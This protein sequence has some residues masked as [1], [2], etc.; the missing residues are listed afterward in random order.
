M[1]PSIPASPVFK[2]LPPPST[3]CGKPEKGFDDT[4]QFAPDTGPVKVPL[5]AA[6][7]AAQVQ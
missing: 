5:S 3:D 4:S 7:Q 2:K 6:P 1:P